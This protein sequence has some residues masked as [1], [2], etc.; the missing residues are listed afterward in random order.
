M[1]EVMRAK[2]FRH[3]GS[4]ARQ[5]VMCPGGLYKEDGLDVDTMLSI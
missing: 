2:I 5:S 1:S 3:R 4:C